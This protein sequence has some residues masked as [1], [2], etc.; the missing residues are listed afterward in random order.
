MALNLDIFT[1]FPEAFDWLRGQ[2]PVRKAIESGAGLQVRD[3]RDWT[4]LKGGRVDDAPY[5]GGAGMVLRVDVVDAA[6]NG[7]YGD[8][9]RPRTVV[10]S[11]SGRLLDDQLVGELAAEDNLALLCGRYEGF[12]QRVHDHLADDEISI[13]RYVL[14]GGELPATV[15]ADPIM[16]R[17]PRAPGDA[18]SAVEESYSEALEGLPEYPHYTRPPEYRGWGVPEVL[19]SGDHARV[20]EWRLEESRRRGAEPNT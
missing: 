3:Y 10:L 18:D 20:R 15:S 6:L 1:L 8:G 11:P 13:G 9:E 19:L 4:P 5:G 17:L 14:A 2:R 7:V 16:R 12:D